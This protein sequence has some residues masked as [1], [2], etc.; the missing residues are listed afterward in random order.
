MEN[1]QEKKLK[2]KKKEIS[3]FFLKQITPAKFDHKNFN[4]YLG[5]FQKFRVAFDIG[6][7]GHFYEKRAL[8]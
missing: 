1:V 5:I 4:P 3:T 6:K 2:L 7:K 8:F